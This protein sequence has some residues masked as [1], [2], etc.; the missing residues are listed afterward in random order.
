LFM[1]NVYVQWG[2]AAGIANSAV[3]VM[4][5]A[6][7]MYHA[8][9]AFYPTEDPA[10]ATIRVE[11]AATDV[12]IS[13]LW[14]NRGRPGM[15]DYSKLLDS[16]PVKGLNVVLKHPGS[17]RVT[18]LDTTKDLVKLDNNPTRPALHVVNGVDSV[19]FS[20][21][22]IT[23][24]WRL[25]SSNGAARFA[26]GKFQVEGTKGYVGINAT[27]FAGIAMLIRTT[28]AGDR[29]L[30]IVRSSHN[31]IN[32][33]VEFQDETNNIQGMAIDFNGRPVAVGTPPK[34]TAGNQVSYANPNPQVR[35][36][37]GSITAAIRP[38][39][40]VPGTIA[41]VM[42]SRG[43]AQVPLFITLADHSAIPGNLYVSSRDTN[44]FTVSTRS[45]LPGGTILNFDYAV[46]A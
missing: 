24:K 46:I 7:H 19:G 9:G 21:A 35:D 38:S 43:H 42:F 5:S 27:P 36:L 41:T 29:G 11:P 20:D 13:S 4:R 37:A 33:L 2:T 22:Y 17:F 3:H 16:D 40:T 8:L 26:G 31:A 34:V 10:A 32:R 6:P 44:G 23:E 45:A 12:T 39:P 14:V 1:T 25:I 30:A 15:G 28:E 18:D